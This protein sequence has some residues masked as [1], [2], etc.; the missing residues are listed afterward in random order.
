[1]CDLSVYVTVTF[2]VL[3]TEIWVSVKFGFAFLT[4]AFTAVFS[5]SDRLFTS[6]TFTFS[7]AV[8]GDF[9]ASDLTTSISISFEIFSCVTFTGTYFL[10]SFSTI[11]L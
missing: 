9:A 8:N 11:G 1:M 7:G 4:A 2:P 6:L 3:S 10:L 5:A